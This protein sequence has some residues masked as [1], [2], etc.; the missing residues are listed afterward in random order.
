MGW[1][2]TFKDVSA[3]TVIFWPWAG[4]LMCWYMGKKRLRR[5]GS[6]RRRP[7]GKPA[8]SSCETVDRLSKTVDPVCA[9][10]HFGV[11]RIG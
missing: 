8:D 2:G 6:G 4:T 7:L 9:R 11:N 10:L 3:L 5:K 1:S